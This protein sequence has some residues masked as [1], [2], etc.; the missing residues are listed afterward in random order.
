MGR[1]VILQTQ[2]KKDKTVTF[3]SGILQRLHYKVVLCQSVVLAPTSELAQQIQKVMS[4][5][6]VYL[7]VKV[8]V[9]GG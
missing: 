3:C 8:H 2:S 1:D 9:C 6:G 7:G 5:V 4:A